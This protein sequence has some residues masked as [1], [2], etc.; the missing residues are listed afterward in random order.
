MIGQQQH[1]LTQPTAEWRV[2][3]PSS[4]ESTPPVT[5]DT[6]EII[7]PGYDRA[8]TEVEKRIDPLFDHMFDTYVETLNNPTITA[9]VVIGR[10]KMGDPIVQ[11]IDHD[12]IARE[13]L[14]TLR[15]YVR[16]SLVSGQLEVPLEQLEGV[17]RVSFTTLCDTYISHGIA[18][19]EQRRQASQPTHI[20]MMDTDSDPE[21]TGLFTGMMSRAK[22]F[23]AHTLALLN[24][25]LHR[26]SGPV[27]IQ[28]D[29]TDI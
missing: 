7:I 29:Q 14:E 24:D 10:D 18:L 12:S 22:I 25:G 4:T 19:A 1:L 13:Q 8:D 6:S 2:P 5:T 23:G 17:G 15:D 3:E 21:T 26:H 28:R 27:S 16:G 11:E 9:D 20:S